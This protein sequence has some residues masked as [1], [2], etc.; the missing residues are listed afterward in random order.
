MAEIK[1]TGFAAGFSR[2]PIVPDAPVPLDGMGGDYE[3]KKNWVWP[4]EAED[5][6]Y[7]S[8]VV[9]SDGVDRSHTAVLCTLDA[10]FIH[11]DFAHRCGEV[12]ARELDIP[13]ENVSFSASHTHSGVS[14]DEPDPA[15]RAYLER[16]YTL[17]RIGAREAA[18]DMRPAALQVGSQETYGLTFPRRYFLKDGSVISAVDKQ[19][20]TDAVSAAITAY[21]G[22]ADKRMRAIRL[23]RSGSDILLVNWQCH[24]GGRTASAT[25]GL[26]S[27]DSIGTM[28][29]YAELW[30]GAHM[31]FFQ[32]ASGNQSCFSRL[33]GEPELAAKPTDRDSRGRALAQVLLDM[34]F[35]PVKAGEITV[36]CEYLRAQRKKGDTLLDEYGELLL[37]TI[38]FGDVAFCMVPCE[39]FGETGLEIRERAEHAM[40]FVATSSNGSHL[41]I[42]TASAY[43]ADPRCR[44][45][46][47][48]TSR[49]VAGTAEAITEKLSDML[50]RGR[51]CTPGKN[52]V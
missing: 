47:V 38:S 24:P 1:T 39:L 19:S 17:F 40:T 21:E 12:I 27:A 14:M 52:L 26:P 4:K 45:F 11:T 43:A 33:P 44:S 20:R 36:Y 37:K 41:Y 23:V 3:R 42:P 29:L 6:L 49:Y 22:R 2:F 5:I 35:E 51:T 46:E 25:A 10:L 31:V 32:G 8:V 48:R 9:I 13:K 15:V 28:R 34:T 16:L 7:G 18:E 50:R 30:T